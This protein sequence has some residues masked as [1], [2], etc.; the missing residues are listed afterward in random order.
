LIFCI[1]FEFEKAYL[2]TKK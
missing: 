1:P 2:K